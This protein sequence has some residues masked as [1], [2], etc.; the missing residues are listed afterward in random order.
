M[1]VMCKFITVII[2]C[3]GLPDQS[4]TS[5]T[6]STVGDTTPLFPIGTQARYAISCPEGMERDGGDDVRNCTGVENSVV[7]M[8]SG[9][10]PNCTGTYFLRR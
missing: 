9:T 2:N 10:A 8:W 6:Y 1:F 5:I 4:Y 7:G 3:L